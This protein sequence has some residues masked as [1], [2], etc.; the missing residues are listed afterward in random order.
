MTPSPWA[1]KDAR[2]WLSRCTWSRVCL[3]VVYDGCVQFLYAPRGM[4]SLLKSLG[5]QLDKLFVP[6]DLLRQVD[7]LISAYGPYYKAVGEERP[8]DTDEVSGGSTGSVSHGGDGSSGEVD[9]AAME[10]SE[11][12]RIVN[13]DRP[14]GRRSGSADSQEAAAGGT[15]DNATGRRGRVKSSVDFGAT[16]PGAGQAVGAEIHNS[17]KA[18]GNL[19]RPEDG[20]VMDGGDPNLIYSRGYAGVDASSTA[21]G[22]GRADQIALIHRGLARLVGLDRG[23]TGIRSNRIDPAQLCREMASRRWRMSAVYKRDVRSRRL[24]LAVDTSPSC[25]NVCKAMQD[26]ALQVAKRWRGEVIV[27]SHANGYGLYIHHAPAGDKSRIIKLIAGKT[28]DSTTC[29]KAWKKITA[30]AVLVSLGDYDPHRMDASIYAGADRKILITYSDVINTLLYDVVIG[31]VVDHAT[32]A[33]K[34]ME[35]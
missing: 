35:V 23:R 6:Q 29:L 26:I 25:A 10:V 22:P 24:V 32:A 9:S 31:G 13:N 16:Q 12:E 17:R 8:K 21:G 2:V 34:L 20:G 28:G 1:L 33:K 3:S 4:A 7:R 5:V 14:V 11:R 30:G 19:G 15:S 18:G 27:V